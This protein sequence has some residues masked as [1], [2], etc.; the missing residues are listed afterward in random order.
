HHYSETDGLADSNVHDVV[1]DRSGRMWFATNAGISLYDGQTWKSFTPSDGLPEQRYFFLALDGRDRVWALGQPRQRGFQVLYYDDSRWH[2]LQFPEIPGQGGG[3]KNAFKLLDQPGRDFPVLAVGTAGYGLSLW[4]GGNWQSISTGNGLPHNIVTG[5]A[6]LNNKFYVTTPNGLSVVHV[7]VNGGF[8]VDNRL[9]GQLELPSLQLYGVGIEVGNKYPDSALRHSRIWLY[10]HQW[11]G[12]FDEEN[13]K[14]T[15]YPMAKEFSNKVGAIKMLPD[16]RG[17]IYLGGSLELHYFN[18][19]NPSWETIGHHSGLSANGIHSLF[20]DFEKN[21]WISTFRG[22]NKI[23]SRRFGNFRF[24][25]GLLA[26]EVSAICEY[27]PGKFIL[28][29]DWGVTF[30]E[31][32]KENDG[33]GYDDVKFT[34]MPLPRSQSLSAPLGRV[35]EIK[36]DAR[37]NIWLAAGRTGLV[38]IDPKRG[39]TWYDQA[40]GLSGAVYCLWIDNRGRL[41]VGTSRGIFQQTGKGF[42]LNE[43]DGLGTPSLTGIYGDGEKPLYLSSYNSGFYVYLEKERQWKNYRVPGNRRADRVYIIKKDRSGHLLVGTNG[44]LFVLKDPGKKKNQIPAKFERNGFRIDRPTYSIME[45]RHQRLWFGTDR[46]VVCW[47]G[48]EARKFTISEGLS[49]SETNRA[50][51]IIDSRG[52]P[53]FGSPKGVS[54]YNENFDE[55][56]VFKPPPKVALLYMKLP[57]RQVPLDNPNQ[58]VRLDYKE[59]TLVFQFRGISFMDEAGIRFKTKLEGFDE[60]WSE[61]GYPYKQMVRY[62]NL[63]PGTYRFHMTAG[64]SLGAWSPVVSSPEIVILEPYYQRWWFYLLLFLGVLFI[65]YSAFR[66]FTHKRYAGRLEGEVEERSAQLQVLENRYRILF[67]ESRDTVFISTPQGAFTDINPAGVGLFG[68]ESKEELLSLKSTK[69]LFDNPKDRKKYLQAMD[70]DGYVQDYDIIF[71]RRDGERVCARVTATLVRD[72]RGQSTAYRGIIRDITEQKQLERQLIQAQKMEAI[73]TLAGG[74]AHDFNN[75]LGVI[76]GYTELTMEDLEEGTLARRNIEHVLTAS[77]RATELVKQILAFSRQG[78][79]KRQPLKVSLIIKEALKLLRS[80]LPSTIDIRQNIRADSGLV[81]A[82]STQIHQVMMNLCTNAAHAMRKDGGT[83]E[84]SLDNIVIDPD[85]QEVHGSIDAGNYLLLTVTDT[86]HGIPQGVMKRIFEPYFTTKKAGEGTGMGLAMIQGIVQSHGGDVTVYSEPGKGTTFNVFLPRLEGGGI[87][88]E[89][90]IVREPLS[91]DER[92]LLVDDEEDLARMEEQML[93]R[94]GYRVT[95]MT[96]ASAAL[97]VFRGGPGQFDI[98]VT[99]LT[100]PQM[101]GIQLARELKSI[102]PG[103]PVI[104]CSGFSTVATREKIK[105]YG[106]SGFVMK[107]IVKKHLARAIRKVLD[108]NHL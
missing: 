39:I 46:G 33:R 104:L 44:G 17:G 41:W 42:V 11:L 98:V 75:I 52:R 43:T 21:I 22:V 72:S 96:S 91:G 2:S 103:I 54:V 86:G 23:S 34:K 15:V 56:S 64:N 30:Y 77:E 65:F 26:D 6:I 105:A 28:G 49:G 57:K 67:E 12:F 73:G 4:H 50:A 84:V 10:S 13:P 59:N 1:Q 14:L 63:S 88:S 37:K 100:M 35:W 71:K 81:L 83:L 38:K 29:H 68:Y 18:Y 87:K 93:K 24:R 9:N 89:V 60:Q 66:F 51:A 53:W 61:A 47:D 69:H 78:E 45:D 55:S 85:N 40:V 79:R 19:K 82:D 70:K 62:T 48:S 76:I 101:T 20:I 80:S 106:I 108:K 97:E 58:R 90:E 102:K 7:D 3:R 99:D 31:P 16:Y 5:I 95:T 94:L 107:P 74:I 25:H 32:E 92:V 8:R 36:T 27:E